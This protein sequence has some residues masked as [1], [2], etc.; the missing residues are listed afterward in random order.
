MTCSYLFTD[1]PNQFLDEHLLTVNLAP[2][3]FDR[4]LLCADELY[5]AATPGWQ[6]MDANMGSFIGEAFKVPTRHPAP[7]RCHQ[8]R[9]P[10]FRKHETRCECAC[11]CTGVFKEAQLLKGMEL[12]G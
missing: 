4:R 12:G 2:A 7:S 8:H 6:A 10:A 9:R 1:I 3:T 5:T 11:A